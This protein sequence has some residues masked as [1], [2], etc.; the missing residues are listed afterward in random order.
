MVEYDFNDKLKEGERY[1]GIL[2]RF[3]A[4]WYIIE[5]VHRELQRAGIDRIF[6]GKKD[7]MRFS[8]E[9][10]TDIKA[11]ETENIFIETVSVDKTN[12]L[13]WVF[14]SIAQRLIVFIPSTGEVFL[15]DMNHLRDMK[16]KDWI[17]KYPKKSIP[18]DGYK[19][20]GIPVPKTEFQSCC[21]RVEEINN[22]T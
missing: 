9:Y 5:K 10:K 20:I 13:G 3:F 19:T 16:L 1:E 17:Q 7:N 4:R 15:A 12:K 11:G 2:D 22:A 6:T 21:I 14:S 8:V 18:N